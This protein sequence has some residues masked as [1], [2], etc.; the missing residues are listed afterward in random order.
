MGFASLSRT[1]VS[2]AADVATGVQRAVVGPANVRTARDNAWDAIQADMARAEARADVGRALAA[3]AAT[4]R[5]KT[6]ARA[7]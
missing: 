6:F 7:S 2:I 3:M 5:V 1:I 4:R